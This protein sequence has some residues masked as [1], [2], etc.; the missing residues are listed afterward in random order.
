MIIC[1]CLFAVPMDEVLDAEIVEE[2]LFSL[3][4]KD[5]SFLWVKIESLV[6]KNK[7]LMILMS[8]ILVTSII[9]S[10]TIWSAAG[11]GGFSKSDYEWWKHQ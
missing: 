9:V 5:P 1:Y 8:T 10:S 7:K 2:N 4:P 11:P 3:I 6:L